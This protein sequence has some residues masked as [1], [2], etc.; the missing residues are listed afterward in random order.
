MESARGAPG[1]SHLG[2]PQGDRVA[3]ARTS[4]WGRVLAI[5]P[6][7]HVLSACGLPAGR[8]TQ[9]TPALGALLRGLDANHA[10]LRAVWKGV[11]C[12]GFLSVVPLCSHGRRFAGRLDALGSFGVR[13]LEVLWAYL[14]A[15]DLPKVQ[16]TSKEPQLALPCSW[17][18]RSFLASISLSL[19][20]RPPCL[21]LPHTHV[22]SRLCHLGEMTLDLLP[23]SVESMARARWL[24]GH[25]SALGP[26]AP[27][28][29]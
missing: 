28:S 2:P 15:K 14:G 1:M 13:N 17:H 5:V 27:A 12:P 7:C 16:F 18:D 8:K 3:L 20:L 26:A 25:L 21:L 6:G 11:L 22:L 4:W 19:H 24:S 10:L 23:L 9:A 29:S